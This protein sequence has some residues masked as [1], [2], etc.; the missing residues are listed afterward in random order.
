MLTSYLM[1]AQLAR[2]ETIEDYI[3]DFHE[4]VGS[5]SLQSL[6]RM[7]TMLP[8][9]GSM[10]LLVKTHY[11]PS[12]EVMR[13]CESVTSKAVYIV[14]NPRDVLLSAARFVGIVPSQDEKSRTWAK[15]FIANRGDP[16]WPDLTGT[17]PQNVHQWSSLKCV[18]Q[19]FPD[20]QVL[21]VR[22]ED[23]RADTVGSLH[24]VL[25]FLDLGGPIDPDRVRSAVENSSI[26]N[27]RR[28]EEGNSRT[29][30]AGEPGASGS[31]SLRFVRQGLNNQ[32][33]AVFGADVE[34]AYQELLAADEEFSACAKQFGYDT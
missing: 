31:P 15:N 9:D 14:R 11:L 17:W 29:V 10:P 26:K 2:G 7:S 33:L 4:I 19:Y 23:I 27:M 25:D 13:K 8:S 34:A 24:Q 28:L 21:T 22:Y 18:R 1:N 30:G 5:D 20:I 16:N 3:P 32:S 12:A 6:V